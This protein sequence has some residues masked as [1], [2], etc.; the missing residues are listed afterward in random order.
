MRWRP[1]REIRI[2]AGTPAG[3]GQDRPARALIRALESQALV[4]APIAL[5]NIP[6]RGGSNAWDH[7]ARHRGD[8]HLLAITAPPLVTN[9]LLGQSIV[10]ASDLTPLAVLCTEYIAFVARADSRLRRAD[11]LLRRLKNPADLAIALAT[12]TGNTNHIALARC[13]RHA[14]GDVRALRIRVFDSALDAAAEVIAG[15]AELAVV[16]A[17]SAAKP[18]AAGMLRGLAVSA[19]QRLPREWADVPTWRELGVDCVVGTW[20]GVAAPP[21]L[22][23]DQ[24]AYWSDALT[25]AS[26]TPEWNA[27]LE[28]N[29]WAN[30]CLDSAATRAFLESERDATRR[31]LAD[32]GLL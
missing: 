11:D 25:T 12:A 1:E 31:A 3:G 30:T 28:R 19:P 23:I 2:V 8:A 27:E 26:R 22:T 16:T 5:V 32:M 24:I 21:G 20:R 7:V 10:D 6:G 17:V 9:K 14:G 29:F 13:T 18:L 15:E 4:D